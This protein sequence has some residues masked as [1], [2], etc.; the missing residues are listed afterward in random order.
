MSTPKAFRNAPER[1]HP[2]RSATPTERIYRSG[3]YHRRSGPIFTVPGMLW[4]AFRGPFRS[5]RVP[6]GTRGR[7]AG[8]EHAPKHRRDRRS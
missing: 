1:H 7:N 6:I 2:K 8:T 5:A 4:N 3:H